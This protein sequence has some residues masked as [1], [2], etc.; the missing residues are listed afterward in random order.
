MVI[1]I[2][3]QEAIRYKEFKRCVWIWRPLS[4]GVCNRN[5]ANGFNATRGKLGRKES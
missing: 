1:Y 4:Y 5:H 3:V 2:Q